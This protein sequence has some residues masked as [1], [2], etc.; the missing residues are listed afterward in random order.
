MRHGHLRG[1]TPGLAAP[2]FTLLVLVAAGCPGRAGSEGPDRPREHAAPSDRV[3]PG[4]CGDYYSASDAGRKLH[5]FIQATAWLQDEVW[6]T[7]AYLRDTCRMMAK[8]LD[9]DRP[10]GDTR[11]VCTKVLGALGDEL[12]AGLSARA[13]LEVDYEPAFCEV[14][15]DATAQATAECEGRAHDEMSA[16]TGTCRG[17]C[18]EA[19][20][21]EADVE[22]EASCQAHAEV[23]A[24]RKAT[25]TQPEIHVGYG[26]EV[27]TD[28]D[29]L[30]AAVTA[31]DRG[32]PR[33]LEVHARARGPATAAFETWA[34]AAEELG[35]AAMTAT[36][37]VGDRGACV[38]DQLAAAAD[39]IA[40]LEASLSVQIEVSASASA[41]VT[42]DTDSGSRMP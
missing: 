10:S 30:G 41:A 22:P 6:D 1:H 8:D 16:C 19:C 26:E 25:C 7:D 31:L 23:R 35:D 34:R 33:L 11:Q 42:G 37:D 2:V 38:A 24:N 28:A 29:R 40:S 32:L 20:E 9:M 15:V 12:D 5:A 21:G 4:A 27:V 39:S 14:D 3:D 17:A 36:R 18:D 13:D